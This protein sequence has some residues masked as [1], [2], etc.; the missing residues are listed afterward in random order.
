MEWLSTSQRSTARCQITV[1]NDFSFLLN[2]CS[3]PSSA[4]LSM[5]QS[6]FSF[7]VPLL[8]HVS[9]KEWLESLT[10]LVNHFFHYQQSPNYFEQN[11]TQTLDVQVAYAENSTLM[12]SP[13][14]GY[15]SETTTSTTS[16]TSS[17]RPPSGPTSLS[18]GAI[19]GIVIG[20]IG[21]MALIGVL[22][23]I[24][25]RKKKRTSYSLNA[26]QGPP[27]YQSPLQQHLEPYPT[28]NSPKSPPVVE[29]ISP[30]SYFNHGRFQSP[31]GSPDLNPRSPG[32]AQYP[33]PQR[34]VVPFHIVNQL[35][36]SDQ[37]STRQEPQE[38]AASE[39]MYPHGTKRSS[40][41]LSFDDSLQ[42]DRDTIA[43]KIGSM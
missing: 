18:S 15:P 9:K 41:P 36:L 29:D 5:I 6:R 22:C 8:V 42:H 32:T 16:P 12:F 40:R 11:S 31:L 26:P 17:P 37:R 2:C 20:G 25:R 27:S 13:G 4:S 38:L 33:I 7:T 35:K 10:P 23:L 30:E 19:V 43:S 34:W 21:M 39:S 14:E 24:C 28:I 1:A 3:H